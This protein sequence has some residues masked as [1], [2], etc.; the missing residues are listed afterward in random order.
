MFS[1]QNWPKRKRLPHNCISRGALYDLLDEAG[2]RLVDIGARGGAVRQLAVLSP[3]AH[4]FACEPDPEEAQR[5]SSLVTDSAPW[6]AVTVFPEALSS[7]AGN[8]TL[9][10]CKQPGLSS[11]L[12]PNMDVVRRYYL[13]DRFDIL[14]TLSVPTI[15]LDEAA[16]RYGFQD[17]CFVKLDTQGTE[18]DILHSG[19]RL[20]SD[21]VLGVYVEVEFQSF[22][23]GQPLFSDVD[24]H[25]RSLGFSLF[26]LQRTLIRRASHRNDIHS[27]R[28]MVWADALYLKEPAEVAGSD[29]DSLLLKFSRLLGLAL[30]F[31]HFD[32]AFE[33]ANAAI[34]LPQWRN[35]WS[36]RV[37]TEIEVL[38]R[39][40]TRQARK[41]ARSK[42]QR[43]KPA[44]FMYT[45]RGRI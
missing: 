22:Y 13:D 35:P 28:Q 40:R 20:L 39:A 16:E 8:A 19:Q 10:V 44:K 11:L 1:F 43:P 36:E 2:V 25:L 30:A 5:L 21:A 17:A 4:Y 15:T 42:R 27:T 37:T 6:K 29:G 34:S 45:D 18:L 12:Q 14:R 23:G 9:Y 24:A 3:F 26:D 7:R 33:I 41:M 38:A 32:L 31:D